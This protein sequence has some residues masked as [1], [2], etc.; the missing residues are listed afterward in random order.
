MLGT[1]SAFA[2]RHRETKK[3]TCVS[4]WPV[5]G[6]SEYRPVEHHSQNSAACH[7]G[8]PMLVHIRS[9]AD[10]CSL[11]IIPSSVQTY[12]TTGRYLSHALRFTSPLQSK[13]R[14]GTYSAPS[15]LLSTAANK[16]NTANNTTAIALYYQQPTDTYCLPVKLFLAGRHCMGDSRPTG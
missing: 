16:H 6:P 11:P 3:K 14:Y 2:F 12:V 7:H 4:R 10:K 15:S 9:M 5:A 8:D 1:V 13:D